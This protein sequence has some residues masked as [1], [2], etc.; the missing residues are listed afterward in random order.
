MGKNITDEELRAMLLRFD[1]KDTNL[2]NM[3]VDKK[4]VF[5]EEH[6]KKMQAYFDD[7]RQQ[8]QQQSK[9]QYFSFAK[10]KK[11]FRNHKMSVA[12]VLILLVGFSVLNFDTISV[13]ANKISLFLFKHDSR[14]TQIR[15]NNEV[16][17]DNAVDI[18]TFELNYSSDEF[19]LVEKDVM[20][21][22]K[23]YFYEGNGDRYIRWM[24]INN[25]TTFA[26]DTEDTFIQSKKIDGVEYNYVEKNGFVQVF[27]TRYGIIF[28][29]QTNISVPEI[30]NEIKKQDNFN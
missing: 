13:Y 8:Q 22:D 30:F 3:V 25:N 15:I 5:S 26:L 14:A 6:D 4:H 29:V 23:I 11:Q 10:V 24:V 12:V 20:N 18:K 28:N 16:K 2:D 17:V 9:K 1:E 21:K 27:Y 19:K 7:L